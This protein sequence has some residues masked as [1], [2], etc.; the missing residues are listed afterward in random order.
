MSK[1]TALTHLYCDHNQLTTLDVSKNTAL[2]QLD[3]QE[4]QLTVLDVSNNTALD[5]LRCQDNKLTALDVSKNTALTYLVCDFTITSA[6]NTFEF[7]IADFMK[8]YK[9]LDNGLSS[10][11]FR[12]Y[13]DSEYRNLTLN[14]EQIAANNVVRFTIP[15]GK[16]FSYIYMKLTYSNSSNKYVYVYPSGSSPDTTDLDNP[17]DPDNPYDSDS[18]N[19]APIITT[20]SLP[21]ASVDVPYSATLSALGSTPIT[22]TLASG[23]LPTGLTLSS[24]GTISGTPTTPGA[25]SFTV[26]ATNSAGSTSRLFTII[27]PFTAHRSPKITT[28]FLNTA[29][30]NSPYGFKLT[31]SGTTPLT[32]YL[33]QGS[34]L[35]DGLTLTTSGYIYGTPTTADTTAFT[36]YASNSAGTASKDFTFTV[37]EAPAQTRPAVMPENLHPAVQ[38][39]EYIC[40]LVALGT[41]PFTWTAE[42]KLPKGLSMSDSGL[43]TGTP[44]KSK[45][46]KFT[47]TVSN[48]YGKET[49]TLTLNV[50][51]LPEITTKAL[52]D[53]KVGKKYREII[54]SSGSKPFMWELE[55][56]LPQGISLFKADN[57]KL[58][59]T[60]P[61]NDSGMVRV[62][63][64]NPVGEVSKVFTL[65]V[66]AILPKISPKSLKA[67]KYGK[68]YNKTIKVKGTEP[69]TL[70]L[71]GDLPEGLSFD[72]STGKITGT[73]SEVCSDRKI[74][75]I[76]YNIAGV[77][78]LDYSLT[79]K[80]I[81]PKITTKKLPDA[82]QG[83]TYS[84]DVEATGTPSITWSA[85]GL[86]SG[87]SM[88]SS[89][90]ISGTPTQSG[91]FKVKVSATN[92]AKT[93][94]KS[95]KLSVTAAS[96]T[97]Q[98][99]NVQKSERNAKYADD[100]I[101]TQK[102]N[103]FVS[104]NAA[105]SEGYALT[106]GYVVIAR[107]GT[108][109]VDEAGMYDFTVTL[110][111]DV[112]AG[113]E[114]LYLAGSSEPSEDD[115]IAEFIDDTGKEV[116]TVPENRK[117]T[118]SV[119]LKKGIIYTPSLAVRH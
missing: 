95:Y 29:Y 9:S 34:S 106:E 103:A 14:P 77:A 92:S 74:T 21:F 8:A 75:A 31:A 28:D 116:S 51:T 79:I 3:C 6:D 26:T 110:S 12:Y 4:N 32:W 10:V 1:N 36:V 40:Q 86:P 20:S 69:I 25:S 112:P 104:D 60:P 37:S 58:A 48:D 55:G 15:E 97:Q 85:S 54:K 42:D 53:A 108:V 39:E 118:V 76:A 62:T 87:L 2:T 78:S 70:L 61:L 7:N 47:F 98:S 99:V 113:K 109:S 94:K 19:I 119:W 81:A 22:W 24:S 117:V 89:G 115:S 63:L 23:D 107:L 50:Y 66:N 27:I 52:K 96:T 68:A 88:N 84:F 11:D 83:S 67:D 71:S 16:T 111:D 43:I 64:S 82:A 33:A 46:T 30:T 105:L 57:A 17:Y 44:K 73:P 35:P 56:Y 114:L 41:P 102:V 100:V 18:S 72:S 13:Y 49:R 45:R 90:T 5:M 91:K 59:G 38:G 101:Q 80:A 93:V 65:N